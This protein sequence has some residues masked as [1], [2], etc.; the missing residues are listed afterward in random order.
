ME[1]ILFLVYGNHPKSKKLYADAEK[2][3]N[4]IREK[5]VVERNELAKQLNLDL[6]KPKDKKHFYS[7]VSPMF[8][9]MLVSEHRGKEVVYRLSYDLFRVY[10]DGLR[11]KGK[12]YLTKEEDNDDVL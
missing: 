12:Y 2:V 6:S 5:G 7:I 4:L 11:R 10:L 8:N 3:I 1:E 9:K